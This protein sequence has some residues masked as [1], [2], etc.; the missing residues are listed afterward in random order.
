LV[1][2][3]AADSFEYSAEI[4]PGVALETYSTIKGMSSETIEL[5][6]ELGLQFKTLWQDPAIQK[7]LARRNEFQ[8]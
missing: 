6:V 1:V 8:V 2:C 5:N 4:A 7:T 3:E